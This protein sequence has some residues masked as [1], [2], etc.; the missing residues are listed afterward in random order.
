MKMKDTTVPSPR[1]LQRLLSRFRPHRDTAPGTGQSTVVGPISTNAIASAESALRW[2]SKVP[3]SDNVQ[4]RIRGALEVIKGVN[5]TGRHDANTL[6]WLEYY[7]RYLA[8]LLEPFA[9]IHQSEISPLLQYEVLML[10]RELE[11][12]SLKMRPAAASDEAPRRSSIHPKQHGEHGGNGPDIRAFTQDFKLALDQFRVNAL[13]LY[14]VSPIE[15]A[16]VPLGI[17]SN[18]SCAL[19]P[20][21]EWILK[22]ERVME[23][24]IGAVHTVQLY[25]RHDVDRTRWDKRFI[26]VGLENRRRIENWLKIELSGSDRVEGTVTFGT[27]EATLDEGLIASEDVTI[28]SA[29]DTLPVTRFAR[30][31]KDFCAQSRHR[32]YILLFSFV[33]DLKRT[34]E[35]GLEV[36]KYRRSG[37]D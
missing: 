13:P 11:T 23:H 25:Y 4:M 15:A 24:R 9:M 35:G 29:E 26:L 37:Q 8:E 34:H 27:T 5:V 31:I 21:I 18:S 19:L 10:G 20:F 12:A 30:R 36:R 2:I 6:R 22:S 3:G 16:L 28:Y 17:I 7:V 1:W 32:T 33:R 14:P